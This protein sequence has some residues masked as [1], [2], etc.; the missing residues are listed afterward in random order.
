MGRLVL[1]T[2]MQEETRSI[3]DVRFSK[4]IWLIGLLLLLF[5]NVIQTHLGFSYIDEAGT[6]C[7][8]FATIFKCA[9][10][11]TKK[12]LYVSPLALVIAFCIVGLAAVG[13]FSNFR[14]NINGSI[15]SIVI[16]MFTCLK[17][18]VT[19]LS[20]LF[21]F[22][23][24]NEDVLFWSEKFLRILVVVMFLCALANLVFDFGMGQDPRF[25]LRASFKFLCGHPSYLVLMCVGILMILVRNVNENKI[26]I[27]LVLIIIASTLRSKA[28]AFAVIAPVILYVMRGGKK[29]NALHILLCILAAVV[30][31]WDQFASYYQ[32]EDS[33]RAELT[34]AAVEIAGDYFPVGTGFATFGSTYSASGGFYSPLYYQY[35]LDGV[36]G[37]YPDDASF[38]SDTFWPIVLGQFGVIGSTLYLVALISSF[39]LAFRSAGTLRVAVVLCFA[40][41]LI[42]STAETSFFNP[43]SVCLAVEIGLLCSSGHQRGVRSPADNPPVN[44]GN[45]A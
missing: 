43:M 4:V 11:W 15:S 7:M 39:V 9:E 41:L 26:Y 1:M 16:D 5:A 2:S 30:V 31:G 33:A 14:W 28:I 29:L 37:L 25:G 3:L 36:F 18:P 32:A 34:R 20:S 22:R 42:A 24:D 17:F 21:L 44:S 45:V 40:Y 23:D 38:L 10:A 8:L 13:L 6:C 19:L 12:E 35:E 27:G